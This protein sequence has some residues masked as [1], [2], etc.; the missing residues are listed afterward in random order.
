VAVLILP[1]NVSP[2]CRLHTVMDCDKVLVMNDGKVWEFAPPAVLLGLES[3]HP[4]DV[5]PPDGASI[6]QA[7]V[8][9]TGIESAA[10]L[11]SVAARSFRR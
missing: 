8:Q 2:P 9:E 11:M 10:A 7:L 5:M 1:N 6:F 3:A 4:S